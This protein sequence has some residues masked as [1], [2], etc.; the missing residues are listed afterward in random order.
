[1]NWPRKKWYI[2]VTIEVPSSLY[3]PSV[4]EYGFRKYIILTAFFRNLR[5][6]LMLYLKVNPQTW[7]QYVE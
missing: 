5:N 4:R 1:M 6:V 7:L 2:P 3:K